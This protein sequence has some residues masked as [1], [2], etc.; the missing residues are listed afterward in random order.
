M[1]KVQ[2]VQEVISRNALRRLGLQVRPSQALLHCRSQHARGRALTASAA[3]AEVERS[4]SSLLAQQLLALLQAGVPPLLLTSPYARRQA[5]TVRK[6]ATKPIDGQKTGTS[7]LRK[8]TK[9]F[10]GENYLANW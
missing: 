1:S 8:K 9:V 5:F 10:T 3:T 7:G 4:H 2:Q 6:F